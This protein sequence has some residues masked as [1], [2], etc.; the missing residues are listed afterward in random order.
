MSLFTRQEVILHIK[1]ITCSILFHIQA[2]TSYGISLIYYYSLHLKHLLN[3]VIK[4]MIMHFLC[5]CV[6]NREQI[7]KLWL[8]LLRL[9]FQVML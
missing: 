5:E 1:L 2:M 4:I 6:Q 7:E 8:V 9:C 3:S